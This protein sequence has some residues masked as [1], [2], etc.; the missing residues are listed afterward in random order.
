ML[1]L[2]TSTTDRLAA[3]SHQVPVCRETTDSFWLLLQPLTLYCTILT[4][5]S[6]TKH[7]FQICSQQTPRAIP[8]HPAPIVN[9]RSETSS[10]LLHTSHFS[11]TPRSKHHL[12]GQTDPPISSAQQTTTSWETVAKHT[13]IHTAT[14]TGTFTRLVDIIVPGHSEKKQA[15][16]DRQE[17][18][19]RRWQGEDTKTASGEKRSTKTTTTTTTTSTKRT[20]YVPQNAASGFLA[21]ASPRHI[22]KAN[23][24]LT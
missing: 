23:E 11:L 14:M 7:G 20:P 21:T 19:R 22:K 3:I 24:V 8:Y 12:R 6:S 18:E 17:R 4:P 1:S 15:Y 10:H 13:H 9:R 2:I 16:E 5:V